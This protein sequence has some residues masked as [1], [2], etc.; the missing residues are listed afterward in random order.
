MLL[1]SARP[2]PTRARATRLLPALALA[3]GLLVLVGL[4]SVAVGTR[5]VPLDTVWRAL[6]DPSSSFDDTVVLSR[7]PR[8]VLGLLSGAALATAGVIMQGLTRNPLGDP[9]LL[10]IGAGSAAAIVTGLAFF[11]VGSGQERVWLALPG[12]LVAVVAVF[13]LGSG[14]RGVT[15]VRLVLAG[16]VVTAVLSAYIQA[17]TLTHPEAFDSYRFW[18]VG[19]LAGRDPALIVETLP[20]LVAGFVLALVLPS[21]LNALALGDDTATALGAT[22]GRTRL[23]GALATAL[24]CAGSTAAVGPIAFIGLAVPHVVRL[25]TGADHRW[26]LP[27]SAVGGA[28]LLVSADVLGRVVA[29]PGELQ[30]GVVTA[31]LGAP[32]LLLAV[33]RMRG[34]E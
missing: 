14:R 23:V 9:G 4:V 12:A 25:L 29:S 3:L 11:G 1:L 10:G 28:V 16:A 20:Y 24:L 30:V 13:A 17:V 27:F 18:V 34:A 26:L 22:V 31:F 8:T 7:V 6:T 21:S 33:R 2:A 19:S 5:S 32:V 15:P